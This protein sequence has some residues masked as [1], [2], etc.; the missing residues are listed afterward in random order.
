MTDFIRIIRNIPRNENPLSVSS[1]T[2]RLLNRPLMVPSVAI[3]SS[4]I[5]TYI[6]GSLMPF[7]ILSALFLA[8]GVFAAVRKDLKLFFCL[9]MSMILMISGS[10]RMFFVLNAACPDTDEGYCYGTVI[11]L[12]RKLSG[13]DQITADINGVRC[14]IRFE[15]DI[16]V[17][18][19]CSGTCFKA[20][21]Q[22]EEPES[23]GNPGEFDYKKSLR[24]KGVRYIFHADSFTVMKEPEGLVKT[25]LSFPDACFRLRERIFNRFTY[26]RTP[27]EKGLLAAVCLGDSSLAEDSITRDFNISGCSHLLAVSG[28]HF[29]GFLVVLPYLLNAITADRRKTTL[30][31]V[32]FAFVIGLSLIH[33]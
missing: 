12:N 5:V 11:W 10:L 3:F 30:V 20:S 19:V 14:S 9:V 31:Y 33:I 23:P 13:K 32:F 17:P 24:S 2:E 15:G 25:V 6:T 16:E 4:C 7:C 26:G 18:S 21:G 1:V 27:E 28:T 8:S 29:S 22:F